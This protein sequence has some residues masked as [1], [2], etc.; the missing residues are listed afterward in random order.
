[1]SA[2]LK[3]GYNK[4]PRLCTS[5]VASAKSLADAPVSLGPDDLPVENL[6]YGGSTIY[7][8]NSTSQA[9][10]KSIFRLT[11][12][13]DYP[14]ETVDYIAI[15]GLNLMFK[16]GSG[17]IAITV[18][19]STDNFVADNDLL[20][21][22]SGLDETDLVGPYLE[23]YILEGALS[24]AYNSFEITITSQNEIP[25]RLRKIYLGTLFDFS[26]TSPY[27]PY[28][29]GYAEN[30][31]PFTSDAGSIFKTSNG[32]RSR[33]MNFLWRGITDADRIEFDKQIR[34][35]LSD[36]PIFLFEPSA[37]DH[38]PLNGDSLV[39]GWANAEIG[40]KDW[41]NNNQIS[42]NFSED[43]IG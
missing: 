9:I 32:R 14:A 35:F 23:D 5:I 27:Y 7:Y 21:S 17:D 25:H 20:L 11:L 16:Y 18:Y 37:S 4:I 22:V 33:Q 43:I 10:A 30:G 6:F 31:S 36:Y 38:A 40:T 29:P 26:G 42:L 3:I 24:T 39:F 2:F 19:G 28:V 15:R 12:G 41:K 13:D 34:Q 8:R 1:M